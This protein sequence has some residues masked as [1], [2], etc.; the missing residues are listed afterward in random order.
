MDRRAARG[1]GA[2]SV[3]ARRHLGLALHD[4]PRALQRPGRDLHLPRREAAGLLLPDVAFGASG[5]PRP[6]GAGAHLRVPPRPRV[7]A[8]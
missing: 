3:P 1:V 4:L 6:G 5:T 8:D 7:V 2:S